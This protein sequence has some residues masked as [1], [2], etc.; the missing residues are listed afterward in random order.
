M[1]KVLLIGLI[2]LLFTGCISRM[3]GGAIDV[4]TL[5]IVKNDKPVHH[6]LKK[7]DQNG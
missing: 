7:P 6:P 4:V 3:V 2:P 5:G 1:K